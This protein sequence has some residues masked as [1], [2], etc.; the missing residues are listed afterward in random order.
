MGRDEQPRG[1]VSPDH[2]GAGQ[3]E[4]LLGLLGLLGSGLR[5]SEWGA[6]AGREGHGGPLAGPALMACKVHPEP[7]TVRGPFLGHSHVRRVSNQAISLL[8]AP[9]VPCAPQ[10]N[11]PKSQR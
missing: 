1:S 4:P 8:I 6:D 7:C 5:H 11:T 3:P 9:A 10:W 2:A